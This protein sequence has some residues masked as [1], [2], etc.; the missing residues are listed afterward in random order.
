MYAK[1]S[2]SLLCPPSEAVQ[3]SGAAKDAGNI[4]LN[5]FTA[6]LPMHMLVEVR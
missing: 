1:M 6:A 3:A 4:L 5:V 2:L